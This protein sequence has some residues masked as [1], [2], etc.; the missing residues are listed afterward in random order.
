MRLTFFPT[1]YPDELLYSALARYHLRSGN[2][3]AKETLQEL[4][5]STTVIATIDLPSHLDSL[6]A[7]L[8]PLASFSSEGLICNHTLLPYYAPFLKPE[9]V[10]QIK[11]SMKGHQWGDIHTR[12]GIVA[13][14]INRPMYLRFCL[15][16]FQADVKTFGEPYWHRVHQLPGVLICPTHEALLHNSTIRVLGRNRHEFVAADSRCCIP[17]PQAVSVKA[18]TWGKLLVL[19]QDSAALLKHAFPIKG[20]HWFRQQYG[21]LLIDRKLANVSGRVRQKDFRDQF[22]QFYGD[23]LL[24]LVNSELETD[25][26]IDWLA[27]IVRKHRK[28][29]HPLRHLLLLQ[30]FD[31][32]PEILWNSVFT[33]QPFGI[34]P[35]ACFNGAANHYRECVIT[36]FTISWSAD[37]KR[38]LGHFVCACGFGYTTSDPKVAGGLSLKPLRVKSFG[39]T[40]ENK[41][42]QLT[43]KTLGLRET[44]RQMKVDPKTVLHQC[45]R[46][47]LSLGKNQV[48]EQK[49]SATT[50][51]DSIEVLQATTR[52]RRK[53][54]QELCVQFPQ[55]SVT[56]LRRKAPALWTWLYRHEKDWLRQNVPAPIRQAPQVKRVDWQVRDQQTATEVQ[57]VIQQILAT[58]PL[59]RVTK[60]R[61]GKKIGRL[62][63]LERLLDKLPRTKS[64]LEKRCESP[65]QYRIRRIRW[66]VQQLLRQ[67]SAVR[68]WEVVRL[69]R[70]RKE[71]A[72][73]LE[74][75]IQREIKRSVT[76]LREQAK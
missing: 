41:L 22:R 20:S 73:Q 24:R 15:V 37:T 76:S 10:A 40:W 3:S 70:L 47:G 17:K 44:A 21:A 12:C 67:N 18:A 52:D 72:T 51:S 60:S 2:L 1:P 23:E 71:Y 68:V 36:K 45:Q 35:W 13:S 64:L 46:L 66:A 19:A 42:K 38:P 14:S 34:G 8:P 75:F 16:C 25:K 4:F 55:A 7:R 31:L 6:I 62:A 65:A 54:W 27:S 5:G 69:A 63:L 33:S 29:F 26:D 11:Q 43:E 49:Q 30:F 48:I 50:H 74:T 53:E 61:I 28:A 57:A 59:Q 56:E 32:T 9:I 39:P 58:V